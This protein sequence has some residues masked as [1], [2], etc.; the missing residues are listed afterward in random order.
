MRTPY[1]LLNQSA[2]LRVPVNTRDNSMDVQLTYTDTTIRCRVEEPGSANALMNQ[3][4]AGDTFARGFFVP[5]CAATKDSLLTILTG[6]G[7]GN[8]YRFKGPLQL[9]AAD[10]SLLVADLGATE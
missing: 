4:L 5:G 10:G 3:R 9:A 8:K 1:H 7:T 2:T 6:P